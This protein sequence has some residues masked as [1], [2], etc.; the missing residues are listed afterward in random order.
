MRS[1]MALV[2][3]GAVAVSAAAAR[4]EAEADAG[5]RSLFNGVDLSGW[6][7]QCPPGDRDQT[8]WGV[9][10][11]AIECNS[12]GRP[13]HGYVWLM[14]DEEFGD[15]ELRLRF[16]VFRAHAGNSGVQVRS[17]YDT[18][19]SAPGGAWLHGPQIDIHPP[20]PWRTGLIY[21]ETDGVRRWIHPSLPDS[22]MT[23]DQAPPHTRRTQLLYADDDN[24]WNELRIRCIGTRIQSWVNGNPVSD[25]DGAGL[26]DDE[27]HRRHNVG[28]RGHLCLQLHHGDEAKIRFKDLR[29]RVPDGEESEQ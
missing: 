11:G 13:G 16:Q 5:W 18:S 26:L 1:W 8:Y 10:D 28:L 20:S 14:S 29:V 3:A 25:L 24:E 4:G 15:F 7:V 23:P 17:R 22:S 9:V 12:V 2:I 6:S 19:P 27:I 21:D